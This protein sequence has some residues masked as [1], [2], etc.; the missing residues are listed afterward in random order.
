MCHRDPL[1]LLINTHRLSM[2]RSRTEDILQVIDL[3]AGA[4][5]H[6]PKIRRILSVLDVMSGT[7]FGGNSNKLSFICSLDVHK[8][9]FLV[10]VFR[11]VGKPVKCKCVASHC[12]KAPFISLLQIDFCA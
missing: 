6:L 7:H 5:F 12:R 9:C 4:A 11:D 10:S 3:M 2:T 1:V 8:L